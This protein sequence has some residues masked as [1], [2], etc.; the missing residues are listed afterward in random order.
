MTIKGLEEF[1]ASIDAERRKREETR[2]YINRLG[3]HI[4]KTYRVSEV[5][6]KDAVNT[7]WTSGSDSYGA[8]GLESVEIIE[9]AYMQHKRSEARNQSHSHRE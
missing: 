3:R 9:K 1:G 2:E 5:V 4:M 6:T 8:L 7:I